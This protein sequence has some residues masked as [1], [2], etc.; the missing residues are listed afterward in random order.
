M[1]NLDA[2]QDHSFISLIDTYSRELGVKYIMNGY[3]ISTEIV[4]DPASWGKDGGPTGDSTY[5]KDVIK[6][7]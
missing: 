7:M 2:P 3:N 4:A 5:M 1:E 6:K